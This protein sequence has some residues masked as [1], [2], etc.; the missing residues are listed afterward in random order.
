MSLQLVLHRREEIRV[1]LCVDLAPQDLLR[2]GD[3]ERGHLR[4]QHFASA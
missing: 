4:A 1:G 2:A 3:R